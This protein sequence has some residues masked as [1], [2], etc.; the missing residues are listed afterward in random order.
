MVIIGASFRQILLIV[1]VRLLARRGRVCISLHAGVQRGQDHAGISRADDRLPT[2]ALER[3]L[4][5][6]ARKAVLQTR[7]ELVY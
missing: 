5:S 6:H 7:G 2:A 4:E 3:K 1:V